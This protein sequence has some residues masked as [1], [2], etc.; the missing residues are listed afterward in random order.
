MVPG[1]DVGRGIVYRRLISRWA[2][3]LEA[4]LDRERSRLTQPTLETSGG[5]HAH[6]HVAL[7]ACVTSDSAMTTILALGAP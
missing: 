2:T 3:E 4:R 6:K 1:S 5:T 7:P